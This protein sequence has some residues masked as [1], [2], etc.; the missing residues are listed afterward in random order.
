MS[1][2]KTPLWIKLAQ[3][4]HCDK[5]NCDC[6]AFTSGN[7]GYIHGAI[8]DGRLPPNVS[9][10]VSKLIETGDENPQLQDQL[11]QS[12]KSLVK[13][14]KPGVNWEDYQEI[15]RKNKEYF[16]DNYEDVG[17]CLHI[18]NVEDVQRDFFKDTDFIIFEKK[19]WRKKDE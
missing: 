3:A 5:I 13:G 14:Y 2:N 18:N 12:I 11:M 1:E 9:G 4:L 16:D 10:L 7:S 17:E 8:D 19:V 15:I 6:K